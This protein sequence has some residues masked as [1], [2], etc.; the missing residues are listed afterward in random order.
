ML[1]RFD[2]WQYRDDNNCWDY[3]REFLIDKAN[4]SPD[5]VPK[6]GICPS[7]KR[8]M[9]RASISV[10]KSFLVSGPA[11]YAVA[12]HYVG[13]VLYHVGIVYNGLVL[14]TGEKIGTRKDT[15]GDFEASAYTVYMLHKKLW[16]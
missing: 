7:N 5:D 1:D 4:I 13:G 2:V 16:H 15:I 11:N 6:F 8:E 14:H 10:A 3:V 9:T 12:C